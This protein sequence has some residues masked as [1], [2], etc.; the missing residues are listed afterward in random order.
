MLASAANSPMLFGKRLWAETRIGLFQQSIDTAELPHLREQTPRV[1]FGRQWVKSSALEIF[2]E[3]ITRFRT[4]LST[5]SFDDD[6]FQELENGRGAEPQSPRHNSTVYRWSRGCYGISDGLP[7][8]RIENRLLPSGPTTRDEQR[9]I[10][11][12][13]HQRGHRALRRHRRAHALR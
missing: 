13:A 11:V 12:R 9:G 7:H 4:I 8:I 5:E 3:D 2:Q 10:L 6:R 1:T